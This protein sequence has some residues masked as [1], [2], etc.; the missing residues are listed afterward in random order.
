M[1]REELHA[2]AE[3]LLEQIE[4]AQDSRNAPARSV[5]KVMILL[6][7]EGVRQRTLADAAGTRP[8]KQSR[9]YHSHARRTDRRPPA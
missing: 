3:L 4:A 1:T 8:Q 9:A 5:Q 7:L 6:A 2:V